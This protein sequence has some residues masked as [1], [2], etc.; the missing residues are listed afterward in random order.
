M[1]FIFIIQEIIYLPSSLLTAFSN[2]ST[3]SFNSCSVVYRLKLI[4]I[5]LKAADSSTPDANN[6]GEALEQI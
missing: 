3:V 1:A 4:L 6:T 2:N 5:A